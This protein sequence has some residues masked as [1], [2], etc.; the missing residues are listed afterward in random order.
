MRHGVDSGTRTIL[1]ALVVACVTACA[2]PPKDT[3]DVG[4][5]AALGLDLLALPKVRREGHDLRV[6]FGLQPLQDD[7]GVEPA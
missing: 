3:A 7:R 6:I 2:H 5:Q 1:A 4:Q